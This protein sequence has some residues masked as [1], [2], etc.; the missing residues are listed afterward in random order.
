MAIGVD[1]CECGWVQ[2][3][4]E[5]GTEICGLIEI[6]VL[7]FLGDSRGAWGTR[8]WWFFRVSWSHCS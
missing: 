6:L 1:P 7:Y 4:A 2:R 8:S 3:Q 5:F